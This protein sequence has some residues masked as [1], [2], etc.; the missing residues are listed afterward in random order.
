[1]L[2]RTTVLVGLEFNEAEDLLRL[3]ALADIGV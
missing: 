1:M 2:W 3:L